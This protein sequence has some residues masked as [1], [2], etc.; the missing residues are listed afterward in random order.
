MKTSE[1]T[2]IIKSQ[3]KM[4][5]ALF[6]IIF[7]ILYKLAQAQ[8]VD[9]PNV[10]FILADDLGWGDVGYHGSVIKTLTIDRLA[11]EG[12][13]LN[14]HYVYPQCT[15][16][17]VGLL[18]GRYTYPIWHSQTRRYAGIALWCRNNGLH[19]KK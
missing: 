2:Y 18:T 9:K 3:I 7:L 10:L 19:L 5:N 16:T 4:K 13:E 11:K 12:I 15:P 1:I 17:R 14:Q 6:L 8:T